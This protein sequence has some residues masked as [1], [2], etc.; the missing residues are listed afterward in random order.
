MSKIRENRIHYV[1]AGRGELQEY[2]LQLT[3]DLNLDGQI[4]LLGYRTDIHELYKTADICVFPS[5]REGLGLA[6]IEGMAAGLPLIVS[7]NRGTRDYARSLDNAIVC[8]SNQVDDFVQGIRYLID[9][10]D[11]RR[12]MGEKNILLAQK[13]DIGN[14]VPL[15]REI[16]ERL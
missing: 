12:D 8:K 1:I 10:S 11:V 7:D 15:I 4:H 2:L 5:I 14:V 6:A 16:F 3:K 9:N 13:Y